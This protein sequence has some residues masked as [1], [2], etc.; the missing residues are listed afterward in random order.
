MLKRRIRA[1]KEKQTEIEQSLRRVQ[2]QLNPHF[3]FN[4]LSSIQGLINT[5]QINDA[6]YYL[7]EFSA[8][9]RQTLNRS[10]Y[11]FNTLDKEIEMMNT[12]I[13]L[14]QLRFSFLSDIQI[15]KTLNLRDIEIPTLILQPLIENAIKHGVSVLGD[16]GQLQIS[17]KEGQ[18][19]GALVIIIRDN[20]NSF[21]DGAAYGYGLKLTLER[22][23]A[24]N[25]LKR[26]KA[27]SL[28]FNKYAGT[29]ISLI[30]NNW[31]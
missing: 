1:S 12:Y 21:D 20:G 13:G 18:Q 17:Y 5:N 15:S 31:I 25:K 8:L 4:A 29:A 22:I 6:N 30:F 27:I 10:Q 26:E 14:E 24:I 3:T 19:P 16:K 2:A 28:E 9:L 11:I 7:H 23:A